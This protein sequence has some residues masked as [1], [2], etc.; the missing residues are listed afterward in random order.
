M[1][2][3]RKTKET[4][5]RERRGGGERGKRREIVAVEKKDEEI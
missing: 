1:K 3:L 5:D 4:R 2:I